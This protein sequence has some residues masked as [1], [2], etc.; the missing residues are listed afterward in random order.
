[1]IGSPTGCFLAQNPYRLELKPHGHGDVHALLFAS[2][3]SGGGGGH[4][5]EIGTN[6]FVHN[7]QEW[8]TI[9]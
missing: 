5:G 8:S 7:G 2:G 1:M 9:G 4:L 3:A 6:I